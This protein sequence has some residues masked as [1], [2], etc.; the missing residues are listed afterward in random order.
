MMSLSTHRCDDDCT[1]PI[2]KTPLFYAP[3]S[4]E[5]A[6]QDPDCIHAQGLQRPL[7]SI[8]A[9]RALSLGSVTAAE[10]LDRASAGAACLR[11]CAIDI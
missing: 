7:G 10:A 3:A 11:E 6:C 8:M 2:H 9:T 4:N 1:C 5:H